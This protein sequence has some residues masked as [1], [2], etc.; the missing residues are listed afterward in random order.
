LGRP[1]RRIKRGADALAADDGVLDTDEDGDLFELVWMFKGE[2]EFLERN[3]MSLAVED[4]R[5][6]HQFYTFYLRS[7]SLPTPAPTI[8]SSAPSPHS[9]NST[10]ISLATTLTVVVFPAP[11]GP[12]NSNILYPFSV[13][14]F[15]GMHGRTLYFLILSLPLVLFGVASGGY[16]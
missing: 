2:Y 14:Y 6:N 11:A 12:D 10:P 13:L 9:I 1:V 3:E 7:E 8:A 15:T 16:P 5:S 4:S